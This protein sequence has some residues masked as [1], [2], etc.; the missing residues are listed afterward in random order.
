[1]FVWHQGKIELQAIGGG[2]IHSADY[3]NLI[4][5]FSDQI[6]ENTKGMR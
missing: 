6:D 4:G 1:V 5:Q 3:S 2:N